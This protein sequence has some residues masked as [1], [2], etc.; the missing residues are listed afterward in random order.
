MGDVIAH[1]FCTILSYYF[2][3]KMICLI[4]GTKESRKKL[5]KHHIH[6]KPKPT[7]I[8][9]NLKPQHALKVSKTMVLAKKNKLHSTFKKTKILHGF[10][11]NDNANKPPETEERGEDSD[12]SI[13]SASDLRDV[14]E[15]VSDGGP[16]DLESEIESLDVPSVYTCGS[17]VYHA[18]C[19]S[20]TASNT[21]ETRR[22]KRVVKETTIKS[23]GEEEKDGEEEDHVS[24][25]CDKPLLDEFDSDNSPQFWDT[26]WDNETKDVFAMAP[27]QRPENDTRKKKKSKQNDLVTFSPEKLKRDLLTF[28][29]SD[30]QHDDKIIESKSPNLI[31]LSESDS[32]LKKTQDTEETQTLLTNET[33]D[34]NSHLSKDVTVTE[35]LHL[36]REK[37]KPLEK[38]EE[39]E[40]FRGRNDTN[41]E[42]ADN[43]SFYEDNHNNSLFSDD[44]DENF[45]TRLHGFSPKLFQREK[46][47]PNQFPEENKDIFGFSPFP[48]VP[49]ARNPFEGDDFKPEINEKNKGYQYFNNDNGSFSHSNV[50][51]YEIS[52]NLHQELSP[53]VLDDNK[54]LSSNSFDECT[55]IK[56]M[57]EKESKV[58]F[59]LG[60]KILNFKSDKKIYYDSLKHEEKLRKKLEEKISKMKNCDKS[61]E[62]CKKHKSDKKVER[63]F[64]NMSFEDCLSGEECKIEENQITSVTSVEAKV[65][66]IKSL[67]RLNNPFT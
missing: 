61:T 57:N 38:L 37:L 47:V 10:E 16:V 28:S 44:D 36:V 11:Q 12:D 14:D 1:K 58:H 43:P 9:Q 49:S 67:Q 33:Q 25:Q 26:P 55:F 2:H 24:Q 21:F 46:I 20:M 45:P 17:S 29:E 52:T 48:A 27:F 4:L 23:V 59:S 5:Q 54:L 51:N 13:G 15:E 53:P 32:D 6:H 65:K 40:A 22:R 35:T 60:D 31:I 30:S 63:G 19:E 7:T 41:A 66:K 50:G 64:S 3:I 34:I 18:E 8:I 39:K 62:K 56:N 42:I